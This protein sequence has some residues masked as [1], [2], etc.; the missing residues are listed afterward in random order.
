MVSSW[1][2]KRRIP[3]LVFFAIILIIFIGYIWYATYSPPSCLDTKQNQDE[4]GIDCGGKN[5]IPC[6]DKIKEPVIL[7]SRFFSLRDG[8]VD[9]AALIENQNEFLEAK[10]LSY[11]IT[12]FDNK[13][14][15]IAK[16][17][18]KTYLESGDKLVIFEPEISIQ[19]RTPQRAILEIDNKSVVWGK[20]EQS[21]LKIKVEKADIFLESEFP[22]VE[23]K[24]KNEFTESYKNIEAGVVL[25][26][27][28]RAVG[29]SRTLIDSLD[30]NQE[31]DLVFTWTNVISGVDRA[32]LFFRQLK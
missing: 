21:V 19:N 10:T 15:I 11:T 31:R 32:E 1:A 6:A 7:W 9:A 20:K 29:V 14:V 18:N 2:F 3:V 24:V 22:R 27:G 5:C 4:D 17:E 12:I 26:S 8:F 30:I 25:W 23:A 16:R 13:N 28:D